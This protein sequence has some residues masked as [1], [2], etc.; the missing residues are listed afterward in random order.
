MIFKKKYI[1]DKPLFGTNVLFVASIVILV[2]LITVQRIEFLPEKFAPLAVA[3]LLFIYLVGLIVSSVRRH[4]FFKKYTGTIE[5]FANANDYGFN[6]IAQGPFIVSPTLLE[7]GKRDRQISNV[8]ASNGWKVATYEYAIYGR[9]RHSGTKLKTIY[10]TVFKLDLPRRMPHILFDSK[11]SRKQQFRV[12]FDQSQ[13]QQLEANFEKYFT[14][15]FPKDYEIDG[16]SIIGPEVIEA[17][18]EAK[19]YDVEIIGDSLYLYSPLLVPSEIQNL[20]KNGKNIFKSIQDE[21]RVYQDDRLQDAHDRDNVS[22]FGAHL[23]RNPYRSL[24]LLVLG[25]AFIAIGL[26]AKSPVYFVI[27]LLMTLVIVRRVSI[28]IMQNRK[29]DKLSQTR[30][31]AD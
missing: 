20:I 25:V 28:I 23:R 19:D 22:T 18:I 15:Y 7:V 2:L 29:M 4:K 11:K 17:L 13:R 30:L 12:L 1:E 24:P 10:Y 5:S 31:S 9:G 3:G 14:T 6:D 8:I 27:G 26:F 16:R 21:M